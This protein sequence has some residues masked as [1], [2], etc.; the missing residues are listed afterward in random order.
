MQA[1]PQLE[2][3]D[4]ADIVWRK[5][6]PATIFANLVAFFWIWLFS[7]FIRWLRT[8]TRRR[9]DA[10]GAT[11][12]TKLHDPEV[13]AAAV[14]VYDYAR[15]HHSLE[16][17]DGNGWDGILCLCSSDLRVAQHAARLHKKLGGW[18]C[19]SGGMGSGPH[20]GANL[21]GWTEAEAIIFAREA[22]RC[23]VPQQAILIEPKAT[24]TGENVSLSRELLA[25]RG[26]D[27]NR[28]V[29]VQKPFME[30][31][32]WATLK[33]V[34]STPEI[35]ISSPDLSFD[36]CVRGCGVPAEV[37][38]AIMVGDLQRIRLYALPPRR[39][40]IA[41]PIPHAVWLAYERLV[42]CGFTM[43]VI[44]T[45]EPLAWAPSWMEEEASQ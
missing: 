40:Q 2:L 5:L 42:A 24:N 43:N 28:I 30:R 33:R 1:L 12:A 20:S 4:Y 35:V 27:S 11:Q 9:A 38:V 29:V 19:F 37:L 31:R 36:E 3:A 14:T 41:Q 15:L 16:R 23:G 39:F 26:L 44:A 45:D 7:T 25:A 18:L 34:W 17:T 22:V 10:A 21:L 32:S 8:E 13:R 6:K